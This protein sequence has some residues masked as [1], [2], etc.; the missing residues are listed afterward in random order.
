[1]RKRTEEELFV[2]EELDIL[3]KRYPWI[4]GQVNINAHETYLLVSYKHTTVSQHQ[5]QEGEKIFKI[6]THC[7]MSAEKG[8]GRGYEHDFMHF[9]RIFQL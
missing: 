9:S 4:L 1:M 7:G 2:E 3:V 6:P 5:D 8:G